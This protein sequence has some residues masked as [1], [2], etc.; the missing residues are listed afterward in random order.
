MKMKFKLYLLSC[1]FFVLLNNSCNRSPE[2]QISVHYLGHSSFIIQFENEL[3]VLT[4]FG[5]SNSYGLESPIYEFGDFVPS[6]VTYSHVDHIDHY[7]RKIPSE[8][9]NILSNCD[10]LTIKNL[11]IIPIRTSEL[12]LE[13]PDNTSFLFEYKGVKILHL[14]D[15]QANIKNINDEK[16][17]S[18]LEQILP[19]NLDL[20]LMT[21]EGR[22]QFIKEAE[23][24]INLLQP[25]RVIPIHYWSVKYKKDFLEYLRDKSNYQI[26]E[27]SNAKYSFSNF[28]KTAYKTK[29]ISLEP[30]PF[31]NEPVK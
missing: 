14:A 3:T 8:V 5:T 12:D 19:K 24:F 26:E 30:A 28:D 6:V 27:K 20:L 23:A 1:V 4:D 7:G 11:K 17:R 9:V 2:T 21:I 16:N 25:K 10:S 18:Y 22:T 13:K 31:T 29:I 15:A